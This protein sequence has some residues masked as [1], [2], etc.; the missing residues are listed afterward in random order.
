MKANAART[1]RRRLELRFELERDGLLGC[2]I[3]CGRPK[4][5]RLHGQLQITLVLVTHDEWIAERADRVL[6]LADGRLVG[7]SAGAVDE[8]WRGEPAAQLS[9]IVTAVP[10]RPRGSATERGPASARVQAMHG[11]SGVPDRV[12][13]R[14]PFGAAA[15]AAGV[16]RVASRRRRGSMSRDGELGKEG[17]RF[18]RPSLLPLDFLLGNQPGVPEDEQAEVPVTFQHDPVPVLILRQGHAPEIV[19]LRVDV[20]ADLGGS[21]RV[22]DVHHPEAA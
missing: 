15:G 12:T 4:A 5:A 10:G 14:D 18:G 22:G 7:D 20:A 9:V 21:G 19:P 13:R 16:R 8:G 2:Q 1:P 17:R 3:P 6:R 11:R